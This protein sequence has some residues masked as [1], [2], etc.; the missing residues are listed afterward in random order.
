MER[1][2][3]AISTGQAPGGIGIVRISG[4]HALQIASCV[5]H[6]NGDLAQAKGYTAHYGKFLDQGGYFDEGVALVFRGPKS[7]TG[8]DVVELSCHG[9]LYLT[10]RLLRAVLQ[11]GAEPAGPGEFTRRAFENGKMSLTAAESVMDL[12]G[13]QG[14]KAAQAAFAVRDGALQQ[15]IDDIRR[16]LVEVAAH[17]NGWADYPEE[18]LPA[19]ETGALRRSLSGIEQRLAALLLNFDTGAAIRTGVETVI[20]GKPNVGKSTLMNLLSGCEKSI[21]SPVAGT[22]RD[23]VEETVRL[24]DVLLRLADTAG[25][26]ETQDQVEAIGVNRAEQR[27]ERA[28][29]ILAVLDGSEPLSEEDQKMLRQVK[30]KP[31]IAVINK[32]DLPQMVTGRD[33]LPFTSH[34]VTLSARQGDGLEKLTAEIEEILG[35]KDWNPA[36]GLLSTERQRR[37]AQR[38]KERVEGALEALACGVTLDAV[39]VEVESAIDALLE[40]TGERVTDSVVNEI[41]SQFCVGK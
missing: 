38:A 16:E 27:M 13:A 40:L 4:E 2:I 25:L 24:G 6:G 32:N 20:L 10:Q 35:T 7:Y 3:A 9:G 37:A 8:E 29:L 21:V 12:I 22:T 11:A 1:T 36:D 39:T 33:I 41:F 28:G 5:F 15:R 18:D 14:K 30:S 31:V 19:V 34:I 17:L 26:R 23:I